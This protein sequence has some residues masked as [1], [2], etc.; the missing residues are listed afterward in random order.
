[1][2]FITLPNTLRILLG[3]GFISLL[4]SCGSAYAP[5][6]VPSVP[7]I[8]NYK[9][10]SRFKSFRNSSSSATRVIVKKGS[11]N[12]DTSNVRDSGEQIEQIVT[13]N[14]G[15]ILNLNER[16]DKHQSASYSLRI[17][18]DNLILS[19]DQIAELGRV[20][21]RR[22]SVTDK[23]K[24]SIAQKARLNKLKQRQKRLESMYYNA[25]ALSDKLDIEKTLADIEEEIFSMEEAIRELAKFS[26]YSKLEVSLSQKS[27]RGPV[28]LAFDGLGWT[29][30]KLFTIRE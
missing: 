11:L 8:S 18:A 2:R 15:H 26:Q 4:N 13:T 21:Y 28:G 24:E 20:T 25:K 17:P 14:G 1:M 16:D 3:I 22:V 6:S 29:W 10:P 9:A 30:G 19:M 12:M 23:T 27:I 5:I 7:S